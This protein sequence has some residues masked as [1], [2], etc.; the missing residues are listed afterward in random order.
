MVVFVAYAVVD[1]RAVM[2][3]GLNAFPTGH[4][5]H[6]CWT[7]YRPTKE[8]KIIQISLFLDSHIE[9]YVKLIH[10]DTLGKTWVGAWEKD[11]NHTGDDEEREAGELQEEP[12]GFFCPFIWVYML[13]EK[14]EK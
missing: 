12:G 8:T 4:A 10:I 13:L 9:V 6:T 11:V 1:E 2:I 3:E 7:P 14:H 5:M